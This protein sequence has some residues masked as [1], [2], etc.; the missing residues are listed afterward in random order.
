MKKLMLPF[1]AT[2]PSLATS[3]FSSAA[4]DEKT[5]VANDGVVASKGVIK[6]TVTDSKGGS[7]PGVTVKLDGAVSLFK[8]TDINGSY[9]FANLPAGNYTLTY[10]FVGYST[11]TKTIVLG[12]D[13]EKV[14]DAVL[15]ETTNNLDEIIVTGYG[16][17]KKREV[18]SA[19]TSINAAQFNKGNI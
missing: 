19:I 16:T 14:I 15:T 7:L 17:Q 12:E 9:S 8:A 11:I 4:A 5:D 1:D 6:G 10:T 18:T 3:V 2:T 13:Q